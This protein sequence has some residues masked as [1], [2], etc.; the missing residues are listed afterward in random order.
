MDRLL[1]IPF[2]TEEESKTLKLYEKDLEFFSSEHERLVLAEKNITDPSKKEELKKDIQDYKNN[3]ASQKVRIQNL[4]NRVHIRVKNYIAHRMSEIEN[5]KGINICTTR[6]GKTIRAKYKGEYELLISLTEIL[7][8]A[9]IKAD[10]LFKDLIFINQN[11]QMKMQEIINAYKKMNGEY[12]HTNEILIGNLEDYL[13]ELE[14]K[15]IDPRYEKEPKEKTSRDTMVLK[16]DVEEYNY[17]VEIIRI[18]RDKDIGMIDVLGIASIKEEN[19]E[20][21]KNLISKT[22]YFSSLIPGYTSDKKLEKQDLSKKE[23]PS[24]GHIKAEDTLVEEISR[25]VEAQIEQEDKDIIKEQE[26]KRRIEKRIEAIN[27]ERKVPYEEVYIT[28]KIKGK[29]VEVPSDQEI[30]E[31]ISDENVVLAIAENYYEAIQNKEEEKAHKYR[32]VIL[33][34]TGLEVFASDTSNK[35]LWNEFIESIKSSMQMTPEALIKR[36][37][38]K[39]ELLQ[40]EIDYGYLPIKLARQAAFDLE[41]VNSR[42]EELKNKKMLR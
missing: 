1:N 31:E 30:L 36:F 37:E 41:L 35:R 23:K 4:I 22:H 17:I 19:I 29:V 25:N 40:K 10:M 14:K 24:S 2:L 8:R 12:E 27:S 42:I 33:K 3:I 11:D 21:F 5:D 26:I 28:P 6:T 34:Y 18:L 16:S 15:Y 13:L 38:T 32:N 39:A 7:D 20:L 9:T